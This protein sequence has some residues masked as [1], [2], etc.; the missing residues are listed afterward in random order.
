MAN[1]E[2]AFGKLRPL[3]LHHLARARTGATDFDI[4]LIRATW[5]DCPLNG[6][7]PAGRV[8]TIRVVKPEIR[9][10]I[11]EPATVQAVW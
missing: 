9:T 2:P 3:A 10:V 6:Q 8:E 5:P 1:T 7:D 4:K 11:K